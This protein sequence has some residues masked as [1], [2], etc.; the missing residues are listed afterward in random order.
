MSAHPIPVLRRLSSGQP[1]CMRSVLLREQNHK[2]DEMGN[3]TAHIGLVMHGLVLRSHCSTAQVAFPLL[4]PGLSMHD[5]G[6]LKTLHTSASA[7]PVR[8]WHVAT[9][10]SPNVG[11]SGLL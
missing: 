5:Q 7:C 11:P 10:K 2:T 8:L 1:P 6:T 4:R 9:P 3:I